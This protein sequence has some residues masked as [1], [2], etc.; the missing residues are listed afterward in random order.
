M[1]ACAGGNQE[2]VRSICTPDSLCATTLHGNGPYF[3]AALG[4]ESGN[5]DTVA[6]PVACDVMRF[7]VL[8]GAIVRELDF[9]TTLDD[10]YTA[11]EYSTKV[12]G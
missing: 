1:T 8:E 4:A 6:F 7:L 12:R 5:T 11:A 2:L 10:A 9:H 3:F